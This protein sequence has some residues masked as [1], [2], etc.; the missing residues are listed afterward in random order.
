MTSHDPVREFLREKG[1]ADHIIRDGLAGLVEQWESAVQAIEDGYAFG[2][3]D[4]LNDMDVRQLLDESLGVAPH[5]DRDRFTGRIKEAD[6]K[7]K[8][9]V[10]IVDVSLW[11]TEVAEEEGWTTESNWWYFARPLEAGP[12]LLAEID[13]VT[14]GDAL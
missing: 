12:E 6:H 7:F 4:Y 3:D 8:G 14:G 1:C 13:E 5:S 11:G 9:L 10:E 2:L